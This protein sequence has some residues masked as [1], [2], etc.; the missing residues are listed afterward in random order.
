MAI[1]V[2]RRRR[3]GDIDNR[4][5]TVLDGLNGSA[6]VDDGQIAWLLVRRF[7]DARAPRVVVRVWPFGT[8]P[9]AWT[10]VACL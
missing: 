9:S 6:F 4:I 7:E 10:D 3:T 5:K 1:D 2:Y 8:H